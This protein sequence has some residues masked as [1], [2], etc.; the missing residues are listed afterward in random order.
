MRSQKIY[1]RFVYNL[2]ELV[3][4]IMIYLPKSQWLLEVCYV[5]PTWLAT[6]VTT[7]LAAIAGLL[8][9]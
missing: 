6:W 2:H 5:V 1:S 7:Y 3:R 8:R 4:Y 9:P